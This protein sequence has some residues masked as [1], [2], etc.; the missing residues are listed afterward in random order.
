MT[1]GG[2]YPEL[3][4]YPEHFYC[5]MYVPDLEGEFVTRVD[6]DIIAPL[7]TVRED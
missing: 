5:E 1:A 4:N 7:T 2:F 6:T 3:G